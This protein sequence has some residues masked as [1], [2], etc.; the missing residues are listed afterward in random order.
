MTED[1]G[2]DKTV[3]TFHSR[4]LLEFSLIFQKTTSF[5]HYF[6]LSVSSCF[7]CYKLI[8]E[9][10]DLFI[11]S[12]ICIKSNQCFLEQTQN[13][14]KHVLKSENIEHWPTFCLTFLGTKWCWQGHVFE[15]SVYFFC[16]VC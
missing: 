2:K 1:E 16:K 4:E 11:L 12:Y 7:E 8:Y 14:G 13:T 10:I 6:V 3:W 9:L 5:Q 15:L